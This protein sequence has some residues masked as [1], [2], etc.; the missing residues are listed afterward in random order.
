MNPYS[1]L[2]TH[3]ARNNSLKSH[4]SLPSALSSTA[5][6]RQPIAAPPHATSR[7]ATPSARH[8]SSLS[9]VSSHLSAARRRI[10]H[11]SSLSAA[12]SSRSSHVSVAAPSLLPVTPPDFAASISSVIMVIG[13]CNFSSPIGYHNFISD[14]YMDAKFS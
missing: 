11:Q 6:R 5:L 10:A 12:G 8:W 2:H 7:H 4:Q 14:R 1:K 13:N 3:L 9:A